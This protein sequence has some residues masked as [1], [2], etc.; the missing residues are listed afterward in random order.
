MFPLTSSSSVFFLFLDGGGLT[1]QSCRHFACVS[2][3]QCI[4][5]TCELESHSVLVFPC[6]A[7]EWAESTGDEFSIKIHYGES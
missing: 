1:G 3:F 5:N 7:P 6:W 4:S 2:I